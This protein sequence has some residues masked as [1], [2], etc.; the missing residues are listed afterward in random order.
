MVMDS[1]MVMGCMFVCPLLPPP[2]SYV[3]IITSNGMVS[4]GKAFSR[5]LG[6]DEVMRVEPMMG[7][8]SL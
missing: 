1:T 8:L 4:G 3:E 2:N 7:L 5:K 6:L